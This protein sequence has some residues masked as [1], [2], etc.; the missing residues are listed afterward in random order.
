MKN[1][2]KYI[3]IIVLLVGGF[4]FV[5]SS[6]S[7]SDEPAKDDKIKLDENG[8]QIIEN[9]GKRGKDEEKVNGSIDKSTLTKEE[10]REYENYDPLGKN[11]EGQ[12][13]EGKE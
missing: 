10:L 11:V 2:I 12:E 7:K 1:K 5:Q 9:E 6:M 13:T 8:K 4:Y 3:I